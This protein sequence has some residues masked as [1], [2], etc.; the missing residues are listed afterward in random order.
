MQWS[1]HMFKRILDRLVRDGSERREDKASVAQTGGETFSA[2]GAP[3]DLLRLLV[4]R[5]LDPSLHLE[6]AAA[7]LHA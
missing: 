5:P 7:V 3:A 6:Y 2:S 1:E 4:D